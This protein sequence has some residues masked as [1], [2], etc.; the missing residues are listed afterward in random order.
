MEFSERKGSDVKISMKSS[1]LAATKF[2]GPTAKKRIQNQSLR[3][4][5]MEDRLVLSGTTAGLEVPF[6]S[7]AGIAEQEAPIY[8]DPCPTAGIEEYYVG[9]YYDVNKHWQ[10]DSQLCWAAA[11]SNILAYTNWGFS[12]S[13]SDGEQG[14]SLFGSEYEVYDYFV[15]HFTNVGG[16]AYYAIPWF[17]TGDYSVKGQ[18]NW[19]QPDDGSG[20]L[21]PGV[22]VSDLYVYLDHDTYG[23]E[24]IG[25]MAGYLYDGYGVALAIGWYRQNSP[26]NRSGGHS[27][28]VWGYCYD[29][30]L[31]PDDPNYYTNLIITNSD[32][33]RTGTQTVD[34]E[35]NETYQMYRLSGYSG[36]NGWIEDFTCL[37]PVETLESVS[38]YGYTGTYDGE[39][40]SVTIDGLD[41]PGSNYTV[42]YTYDG[43]STP[44]APTYR[45]PGT[46]NVSVVVVKNEYEAVLSAQVQV[47]ISAVTEKLNVPEGLSVETYGL[48]RQ[49]VSWQGVSNAVSYE[50]T[51]SADNGQTWS[52]LITSETN[53]VITGLPYGCEVLYKV[54]AVGG[55]DFLDSDWSD[56]RLLS[57][58]PMDLDGDGFIGPGDFA[59]LSAAWFTMEGD[60]NWDPRCDV[61]GDGFV[62]PGDYSFVSINWF[63]MTDE[64]DIVYPKG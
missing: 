20:N 6:T 1:Q 33:S 29:T 48:N 45:T 32:D 11:T 21:Y 63:K 26:T 55:V 44:Y 23:G 64:D 37:K 24:L 46:H 15:E 54:R 61:D 19:A 2:F 51:W 49:A 28:T 16:H 35:W 12:I 13:V 43:V 18:S 52:T 5:A 56:G 8:G 57:V 30:N 25:E 17:A 22:S 50:L 27:L 34:L 4:E 14:A 60:D 42:T 59:I 36:G 39:Y 47:S 10:N 38:V 53:A 41:D 31:S 40:H 9:T 3:F 7:G 62:G 58:I